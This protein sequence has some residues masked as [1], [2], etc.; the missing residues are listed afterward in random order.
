MI[1]ADGEGGEES[2]VAV[3][4][5]ERALQKLAARRRRTGRYLTTF[6]GHLVKLIAITLEA[7]V[8]RFTCHIRRYC[9]FE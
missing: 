2:G 9:S 4:R 7:I 1:V 5:W 8:V 6:S 3:G